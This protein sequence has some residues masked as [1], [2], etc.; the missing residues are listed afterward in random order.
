M[1][2]SEHEYS[3]ISGN[4]GGLA[5]TM[6]QLREKGQ[7]IPDYVCKNYLKAT[8]DLEELK[9]NKAKVDFKAKAD[10]SKHK[11]TPKKSKPSKKAKDTSK[12][13]EDQDE[14]LFAENSDGDLKQEVE[15]LGG[16]EKD[17]PGDRT[18]CLRE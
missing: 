17:L 5:R 3:E 8:Q 16:T 18:N 2:G 4:Q 12:G 14:H 6:K 13:N 1:S 11:A 9:G 10:S 15:S 7:P